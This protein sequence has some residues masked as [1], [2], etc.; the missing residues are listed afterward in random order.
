MKLFCTSCGK[1]ILTDSKFCNYCG[2]EV[3]RAVIS[4]AGCD[5]TAKPCAVQQPSVCVKKSNAA[6]VLLQRDLGGVKGR[7]ALSVILAVIMAICIAVCML[8]G[9]ASNIVTKKGVERILDNVELSEIEIGVDADDDYVTLNE[10][11][12]SRLE[13]IYDF[14]MSKREL[15]KFIDKSSFKDFI[16]KKLWSLVKDILN[17][18]NDTEITETEIARLLYENEELLERM[19]YSLSP[20]IRSSIVDI[21]MQDELVYMINEGELFDELDVEGLELI[22]ILTSVYIRIALIAII[23]LCAVLIFL[24]NRRTLVLSF[25][26][27]GIALICA[28]G[29]YLLLAIASAVLPSAVGSGVAV[30]YYILVAVKGVLST[31][32][33]SAI[34]VLFAGICMTVA[35]G[36]LRRYVKRAGLSAQNK[37][38][39]Y[40]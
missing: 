26:S 23:I 38:V 7:R 29:F 27:V 12:Y 19:G 37:E 20:S 5:N 11:M 36:L 17:D 35:A 6:N 4:D 10:Y 25:K 39:E 21:I 33:V 28:G 1:R 22:P 16:E 40:A 18:D 24:A 3:K 8:L 14:N 31:G 2:A 30:A 9:V 13:N 32:V 34:I 15:A